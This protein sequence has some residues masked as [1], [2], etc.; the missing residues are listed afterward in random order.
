MTTQGVA[1]GQVLMQFLNASVFDVEGAYKVIRSTSTA[2]AALM[3]MCVVDC[4][5]VRFLLHTLLMCI[6]LNCGACAA[7]C[8]KLCWTGCVCPHACTA[9]AHS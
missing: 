7:N 6:H 8:L 1:V 5:C 9:K 4:T 2:A 3:C